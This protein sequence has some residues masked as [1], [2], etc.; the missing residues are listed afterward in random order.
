MEHV[1]RKTAFIIL[2]AVTTVAQAVPLQIKATNELAVPRPHQTIELKARD[3]GALA[4]KN[5]NL[6]H[7]KDAAGNEVLCQAIDLDGDPLRTYDAVIF[8]ADFAPGESKTFTLTSGTTQVFRKEQFKAFG[9]FARERFDDFAWEN[10]RIAHRVYGRALET[11]QGEPLTSSAVD[12]WS[13]RV[14]RMVINDWYLADDYHSDHGEGADVY[15]AGISRGCGGSGLWADGRLWVSRN[16][17]SSK[18]LANGPIRVLFE[19]EYGPYAVNDMQ[20]GETKHISLDAGQQ[21]SQF[22]CHYQVADPA[23]K[24]KSLTA[25]IGL[26]KVPGESVKA[27]AGQ[28]W[29]CKWELMEKDSGH[30]GLA[31]ITRP[32]NFEKAMADS[33]NQLLLAK[34]DESQKLTYWSGFCWDKAE[35]ITTEDAWLSHVSAF[36]QGLASPI[37]VEIHP[38]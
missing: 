26:K 15:T 35:I 14:P 10:D 2:L 7:V 13:K 34:T 5:L 31:V 8:Q 4:A 21:F 28:G 3:L 27:N 12:I 25:A 29:L 32:K 24:S 19:L 20:V 36:A 16:F 17:I 23:S 30:Q 18:V 9:R 11:W 37:K 6:I 1:P 38:R 33:L 22:E